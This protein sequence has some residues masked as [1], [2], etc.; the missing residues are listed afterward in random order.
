MDWKKLK[1][2]LAPMAGYT[3]AAFRLQCH[4]HGADFGV[5]ELIS[6]E[7]IV[8]G[9]RLGA[10]YARVS[11]EERPVGIQ[12]FGS[13][14]KTISNAA[15][16]LEKSADFI[17]L[18][19]G[20]PAPKVTRNNG[21]AVLLAKPELIAEIVLSVSSTIR[22]P[23]TAKMRLGISSS[24]HAVEIARL[25]ERAGASALF[26]HAR[27]LK[28]GYAGEPDWSKIAEIKKVL[29]IPIYG[30]GNVRIH[31]NAKKMFEETNCDG[32]LVGRAAAGNPFIFDEMKTGQ[33]VRITQK[34]RSESFI[35]YLALRKKLGIIDSGTIKCQAMA[36][37]KGMH[38]AAEL[39]AKIAKA[40]N[41]EEIVEL[42]SRSH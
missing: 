12:L 17:D 29:S 4:Q 21:G 37:A 28:Q 23:T 34:Q 24:A 10:E 8:R 42:F 16:M 41:K 19:F 40:E 15:A 7:S 33:R 9:N 20:C 2:G 38:K 36:F 22:K 26:V 6:A 13:N 31:E 1:I 18:N 39:R 25:I 11:E 27:T 3:D 35:E 14:P 30:N 5:T 32:V